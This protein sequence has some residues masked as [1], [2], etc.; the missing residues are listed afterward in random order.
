MLIRTSLK[1]DMFKGR[2]VIYIKAG[3]YNDYVTVTKDKKNVFVYGDGMTKT[4]VT[5]SK[6]YAKGF[7]TTNTATF[8]KKIDDR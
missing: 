3:I 4:L 1:A 8:C 5:G 7:N 6:R 2:Y